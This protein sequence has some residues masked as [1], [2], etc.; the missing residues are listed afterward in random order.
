MSIFDKLAAAKRVTVTVDP[1][2]EPDGIAKPK[3]ARHSCGAV[4]PNHEAKAHCPTCHITFGSDAAFDAH[5]TGPYHPAGLRACTTANALTKE[6]WTVTAGP[7]GT[8]DIY[9]TP[10]PAANPWG[11]EK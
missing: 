8:A 2:E 5:R 1:F 11:D 3:W 10:P 6:G 9:R 7:E 4:W